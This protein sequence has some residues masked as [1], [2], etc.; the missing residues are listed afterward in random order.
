MKTRSARSVFGTSSRAP[1]TAAAPRT[2]GPG[3][4]GDPLHAHQAHGEQ[5]RSDRPTAQR[6]PLARAAR[7][8]PAGRGSL[9]PGPAAYRTEVWDGVSGRPV[10]S[11]RPRS[12]TTAI[13][14]APRPS[15]LLPSVD[16]PGPGSY[17]PALSA[18]LPGPALGRIG[19]E[20]R[21]GPAA[22]SAHGGTPGP[23][24]H[25]QRKLDSTSNHPAA[26]RARFGSSA[27]F[28]PQGGDS[29]PGPGPAAYQTQE[30]LGALST[31]PASA[32]WGFGTSAAR[33]DMSGG[34]APGPADYQSLSSRGRSLDPRG[35]VFGQQAR[36]VSAPGQGPHAARMPGP[37]DYRPSISPLSTVPTAPRARV[38][39]ASRAQG[40]VLGAG[41]GKYYLAHE[42]LAV[43]HAVTSLPTQ[44]RQRLGKS[45]RWGHASQGQG[46]PGP[47]QYGYTFRQDSFRAQ[48]WTI[49]A[50]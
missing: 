47:D 40:G 6:Q 45:R 11:M 25:V 37:A 17:R 19:R 46:T 23:A 27:R 33:P 44:P 35:P 7:G 21:G 18:V 4:Y 26:P 2:P 3:A 42:D 1:P 14:R 43:D 10:S 49:R 12:A 34:S 30:G 36:E 28:H 9:G 48:G 32:A 22:S 16:T 41:A 39:S 15:A 38:G 24:A 8:D 31:R 50:R 13:G 20:A 29:G 5:P